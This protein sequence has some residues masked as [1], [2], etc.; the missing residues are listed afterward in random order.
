MLTVAL[1]CSLEGHSLGLNDPQGRI[2]VMNKVR[3]SCLLKP[4]STKHRTDTQDRDVRMADDGDRL[5]YE[6]SDQSDG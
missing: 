4:Y 3:E 6:H 5:L 2:K 1:K